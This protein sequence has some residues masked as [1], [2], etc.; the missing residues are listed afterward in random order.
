MTACNCAACMFASHCYDTATSLVILHRRTQGVNDGA[1]Q[2]DGCM[3]QSRNTKSVLRSLGSLKRD[4]ML[5][6]RFASPNMT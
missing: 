6:G 5:Q 4:S 1:V 3:P 2:N